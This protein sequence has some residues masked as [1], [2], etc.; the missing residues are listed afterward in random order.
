MGVA[1]RSKPEGPWQIVF[2]TRPGKQALRVRA[3]D[4]EGGAL[5]EWTERVVV[6]DLAAVD[7]LLGTLRLY[8]AATP[9]AWRTLSANLDDAAPIASRRLRRTDRALVAIP[10]SAGATDAD[11]R[12]ELLSTQGKRLVTLNVSRAAADATP[13]VELPLASLAQAQYVLRV[14]AERVGHEPVSQA[15]GF[16]VVP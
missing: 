8:R 12:A 13:R 16:V 6:P 4:D 3:E 2:L 9:A 7:P 10:L 5:D 11:L 15:L 1:D 14:A